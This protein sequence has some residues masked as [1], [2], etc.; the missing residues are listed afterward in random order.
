MKKIYLLLVLSVLISSCGLI[1]Y[2]HETPS[3]IK[4]S[5]K[6]T[7]FEPVTVNELK[8]IIFSDTC[9]FKVAIIYSPCCGACVWSMKK[10]L[11]LTKL[12]PSTSFYFVMRDT[13]CLNAR[14]NIVKDSGID[15]GQ[16]FVLCDT[17]KL[18]STSNYNKLSNIANFFN[19][20]DKELK[21]IGIPTSMIFNGKNQM[22]MN[23]SDSTDYY[24]PYDIIYSRNCNI[25]TFTF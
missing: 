15:T 12:N 6:Q 21:I 19:T 25:S 23:K 1:T 10:Y 17:S 18:F 8:E 22:K 2:C 20:S 9:E 16:H 7:E 14:T 24:V 5:S 11:E 13:G 4:K 3:T